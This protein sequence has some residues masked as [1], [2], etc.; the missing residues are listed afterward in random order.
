M[1]KAATWQA[2]GAVTTSYQELMPT[3]PARFT[4]DTTIYLK[5]KLSSG[6]L[7]Y[8]PALLTETLAH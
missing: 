1:T 8:L 4:D 6:N 3:W 2:K 5:L 7:R